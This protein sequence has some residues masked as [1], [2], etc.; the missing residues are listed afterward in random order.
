L[1]EEFVVVM[2]ELFVA[3]GVGMDAIGSTACGEGAGEV[4]EVKLVIGC[5][6]CGVGFVN[7]GEMFGSFKKVGFTPGFESLLVGEHGGR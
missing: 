1:G 4:V 2:S 6:G 5:C 3:E 7:D